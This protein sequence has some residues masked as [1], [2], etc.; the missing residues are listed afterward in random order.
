MIEQLSKML[1]QVSILGRLLTFK[2]HREKFMS[3]F[4][5]SFENALITPYRLENMVARVSTS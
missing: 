5:K 2:Q 3:I 4:R 1:A